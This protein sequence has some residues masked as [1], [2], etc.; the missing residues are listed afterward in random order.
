MMEWSKVIRGVRTTYVPL[1]VMYVRHPLMVNRTI[2]RARR[3][4]RSSFF[5]PS[6][7]GR[8]TPRR[9]AFSFESNSF[10]TMRVGFLFALLCS[11]LAAV[12][13]VAFAPAPAFKTSAAGR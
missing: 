10:N 8:R 11:A 1:T 12:S 5:V 9:F 4:E 3:A 13:T 6:S 2:V 7:V